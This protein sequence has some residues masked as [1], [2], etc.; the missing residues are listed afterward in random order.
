MKKN[1][2]ARVLMGEDG[3]SIRDAAL[4]EK[5]DHVIQLVA[6]LSDRVE[7]LE[8]KLLPQDPD[9]EIGLP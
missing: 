4:D 1:E 7:A 9:P 6:A 5:V 2:R 8:A 3:E